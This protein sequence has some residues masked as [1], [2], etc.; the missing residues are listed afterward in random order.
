MYNT[1]LISNAGLARTAVILTVVILLVLSTVAY[2]FFVRLYPDLTGR[3]RMQT[4][5]MNADSV[6][7][8]HDID[9]IYS[10]VGTCRDSTLY[11]PDFDIDQDGCVDEDKDL[12]K[13]LDYYYATVRILPS[14]TSV[15]TPYDPSC[16]INGDTSCDNADIQRLVEIE[17][18][19]ANIELITS[20]L[21]Q[22]KYN[23]QRY[24]TGL[25]QLTP[26]FISDIPSLREST[27]TQL[28]GGLHYELCYTTIS[29]FPAQKTCVSK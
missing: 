26:D 3:N 24:P 20:A 15:I 10:S 7:D 11:R 17:T 14:P 22:Y 29:V 27:Y 19:H 16:D 4:C 1:R 9:V 23:L 6:C 13:L 25:G 18:E 8:L 28:S 5:D 12:P 21:E 2:L